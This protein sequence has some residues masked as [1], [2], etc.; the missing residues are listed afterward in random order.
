M[1]VCDCDPRA[2]DGEIQGSHREN[3]LGVHKRNVFFKKKLRV[4]LQ[5]M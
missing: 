5:G 4:L 3:A 2:R 1:A